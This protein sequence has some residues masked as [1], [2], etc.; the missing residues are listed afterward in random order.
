[1]PLRAPQ[2][3]F[4]HEQ[5]CV[6]VKLIGCF[7]YSQIFCKHEEANTKF[8]AI[9][10]KAMQGKF[11]LQLKNL[12][13]TDISQIFSKFTKIYVANCSSLASFEMLTYHEEANTKFIAITMEV[14]QANLLFYVQ[15]V[16]Q[17]HFSRT[18]SQL[19]K[20]SVVNCS[21]L[22]IRKYLLFENSS[23]LKFL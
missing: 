15:K 5:E 4:S 1:M 7:P 13:K 12:S 22:A 14:L 16:L 6:P 11:L 10:M 19:T 8:I 9:T 21:S 17:T 20:I 18:L 2:M 3:I 23:I